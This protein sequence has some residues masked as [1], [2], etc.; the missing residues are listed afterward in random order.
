MGAKD[1]EGKGKTQAG[2][3][4]LETE[5]GPLKADVGVGAKAGYRVKNRVGFTAE[6]S[7]ADAHI[8][9][10]GAKFGFEVSTGVHDDEHSSGVQVLG[11][12]FDIKKDG[13]GFSVSVLGSKAEC[14]IM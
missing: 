6:T 2:V 3:Q 10:L 14:S 7:T 5:F 11:T 12:G 1:K 4:V 13:S 8:G 9:P